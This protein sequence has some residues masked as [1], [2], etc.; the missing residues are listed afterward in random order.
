M[1][2]LTTNFTNDEQYS[3]Y[4][5]TMSARSAINF[6]QTVGVDDTIIT[7][8]TCTSDT[9]RRII[10]HAKLISNVEMPR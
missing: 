3:T 10:V 4:L 8:Q 6:N 9:K 1:Y 7:L 5:N 2:Y